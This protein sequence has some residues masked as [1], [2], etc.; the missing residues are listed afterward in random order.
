M[1]TVAAIYSTE[2]TLDDTLQKLYA[3]DFSSDDVTVVRGQ[4]TDMVSEQN[5]TLAVVAGANNGMAV[6]NAPGSAG[7]AL[8]SIDDVNLTPDQRRFYNE[9]LQ[10]GATLVFV[11]SDDANAE[12]LKKAM[13]GASRVDIVSS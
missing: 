11:D 7:Y 8:G 13:T 10:D 4:E 6:T 12:I 3:H 5:G 1:T 9:Q 2:A